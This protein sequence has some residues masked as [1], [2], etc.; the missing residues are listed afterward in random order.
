MTDIP[1]KIAGRYH[2]KELLGKGGFG[3]VYRATQLVE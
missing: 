3:A 2:I 1:K